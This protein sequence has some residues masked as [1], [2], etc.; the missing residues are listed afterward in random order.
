ML[1]ALHLGRAG[2]MTTSRSGGGWRIV[3]VGFAGVAILTFG[4]WR[5]S[6][7][8]TVQLTGEL[9]T[10][11]DT[12]ELVVAITFDDGPT[13]A[14]TDSTLEALAAVGARATFFM[15]GERMERWPHLVE[16]VLT[17]GHEV[18]NHSYDHPA[19]VL[20]RPSQ[21]KQQVER[22]DSLIRAAGVE[23]PIWFRPPYG[24]RLV[25]LPLY[26]RRQDRPTV[27]W[28]LEPDSEARE[29]DAVVQYVVE[30]IRPGS[31]L[32]LHTELPARSENRSALHRLLLELS[33]RGYRFVTLS[34]LVAIGD[35]PS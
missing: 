11:V 13:P 23:G 22:T 6:N 32:L 35:A 34:E 10:R 4:S 18:G 7:S 29:A 9:V 24:K 12:D 31:I 21:V 1:A 19:M 2:A 26:L 28:D 3:L 20:M 25:T 5:L 8:R 14:L 15:V 27:L 17:Q 33:D 30:R 16:R